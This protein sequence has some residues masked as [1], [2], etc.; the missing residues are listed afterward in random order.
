MQKLKARLQAH[1]RALAQVGALGQRL[2]ETEAGLAQAQ[3]VI[4]LKRHALETATGGQ[5]TGINPGVT[6][7]VPPT[8]GFGLE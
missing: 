4:D 5:Q 7:T 6:A 2:R 3:L 1:R 8:A